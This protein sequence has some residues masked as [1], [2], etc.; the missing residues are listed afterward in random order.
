MA[1]YYV[2]GSAAELDTLTRW[3]FEHAGGNISRALVALC[4][5][6]RVVSAVTVQQGPPLP[7]GMV[8]TQR[9]GRAL[10]EFEGGLAE[11]LARC[12]LEIRESRNA[13]RSGRP[14]VGEVVEVNHRPKSRQVKRRA[15]EA[16]A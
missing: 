7:K 13:G 1:G 10:A 14:E 12:G 5:L 11:V 8:L 3:A 4:G 2:R 16:V 6:A 15:L 9:A